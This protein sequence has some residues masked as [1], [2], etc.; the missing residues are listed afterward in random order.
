MPDIDIRINAGKGYNV[1]VGQGILPRCGEL[2]AATTGRCRTALVTD[3]TV[4]K[5]YL[6]TVQKSLED[7]GFETCVFAFP[8]GETSKNMGVLSDMLEFLAASGLTRSGMVAA[9]GGGVVGDIAGFASGVY[10]R[11]IKLVQMPTTLLAAVDSS[12][13]G[14]TAVDLGAGKN[15][16]GVFK[17]PDAVLCDTDCLDTLPPELFADGAA[18]VIKYGIIAD[19]GLF[20]MT[21]NGVARAQIEQ[22]ISRCVGIKG[23]VVERDEF[24]SGER[25]IL[26]FGH[27]IGHAA[28]KCSG[29][30]I[31]HG[32]AVAMGMAAM[33]RA[34]E[35]LGYTR[36]GVGRMITE[37]IENSGLPTE[38]PFG[39]S[40]LAAAALSDKKRRGDVI[41][42]V[43]PDRIGHCLIEDA[44]VS[45]LERI[46][47]LGMERD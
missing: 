26:N 25:K 5:L 10:L 41:S 2:L 15:L 16:A 24:E 33:A 4:R 35:K 14:K 31:S 30:G 43:F 13:G 28:E 21:R 17:Q 19:E 27:T 18:E 37:A 11:G 38:V 12:V 23:G 9:L 42:L 45:E 39:A 22:V 36:P 20:E 40:E 29:Y 32:R 3:S 47:A 34:G 7:S 46:I 1:T 8:A 6:D 44:A